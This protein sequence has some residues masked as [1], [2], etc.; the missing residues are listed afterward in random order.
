M[1]ENIKKLIARGALGFPLGIAISCII[2]AILSLG[3]GQGRYLSCVPELIEIMGNEARA[4]AF[5]MFLS[6]LLGTAF[7][8]SSVIWELDSWSILK[9]SAIYFTITAIV[10]MPIAYVVHWME[11]TLIGFIEYL[12]VYVFIFLI[13]WIVQYIG[14]KK[15][16]NKINTKI[17]DMP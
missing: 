9:Q 12:G 5:Q 11:H 7:G 14:W 8:A 15:R 13:M 6:G 3:W 1:K 17:N 10:M 16:I 2:T 4:V